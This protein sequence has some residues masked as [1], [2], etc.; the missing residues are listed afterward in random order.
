MVY[1]HPGYAID[2]CGNDLVVCEP[3]PV[4]L[5]EACRAV[6]DPC[7][8]LPATET[9]TMSGKGRRDNQRKADTNSTQTQDCWTGLG[10]SLIAVNL[11]LRYDEDLTQGQRP[12]FR[13]GCSDVGPCEY[14]RVLEQ[15]CVHAEKVPIG[16][17]WEDVDAKAWGEEFGARQVRILEELYALAG[18]GSDLD[19]VLR[20]LKRH[21]PYQFC[22][23][24][25]YIC[26]LLG[27]APDTR[28]IGNPKSSS[29]FTSIG[30]CT[31]YAADVAVA[32]RIE[33][34]RLPVCFS[35]RIEVANGYQCRVMLVD[36]G[37]PH[38]RLI[39]KDECRPLA[40]GA[41]DLAHYIWQPVDYAKRHLKQLGVKVSVSDVKKDVNK[42]FFEKSVL[43]LPLEAARTLTIWVE[44]DLM[45]C[46][47]VAAFL[48]GNGSY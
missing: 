24:E 18:T 44:K 14:A 47:R 3:L 34:C 41:L 2:C 45:D 42:G 46:P 9:S 35:G 7:D 11:T 10:E 15:P 5:S 8:Q 12:M 43:E 37:V 38:R 23:V 26:C 30:F 25:D 48:P 1:V 20:Y 22:F 31:P 28:E 4:D 6:E 33:A 39:R 40:M 32:A 17:C 16:Q 13:S 19:A 36:T 27:Q 29:G 21:P